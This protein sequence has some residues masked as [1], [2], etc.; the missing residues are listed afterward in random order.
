MTVVTPIKLD[1]F[2][3][4]RESPGKADGAHGGLGPGVDHSDHLHRGNHFNDG[5]RHLHFQSGG[6]AIAGPPGQGV[7]YG[8]DN[9]RVGMSQDHG[10]PGAHVIDV[11]LPIDVPQ[12]APL[13]PVYEWGGNPY[14][15]A[16]TDRAVDAA[17]NQSS[18]LFK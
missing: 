16:R 2:F 17:G 15:F 6:G 10:T 13:R 14:R 7:C 11:L 5:L 8:L 18:G 12:E 1:D 4:P 9:L 3:P